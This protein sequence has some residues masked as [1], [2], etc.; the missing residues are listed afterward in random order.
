M[1]QFIK[2][3]D[4]QAYILIQELAYKTWPQTFTGILSSEQIA[5][6]LEKMYSLESLQ[7]QIESKGHIFILAKEEDQCLGFIS[8][9]LHHDDSQFT[10][11]HKL[12]LLPSSQG[13][14]LGKILIET[15]AEKALQNGDIMLSLNVNR[16]N[17]AIDFYE[18][19]GFVKVKEENISIGNGFWMEDFVMEKQLVAI[20]NESQK[21]KVIV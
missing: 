6:M 15:V 16:Q 18:K 8:Y 5:F 4:G 10:K 21:K 7:E 14:G 13:K 3:T 20:D 17:K 1:I 2:A 11:I 12:Y 9:E 19:M